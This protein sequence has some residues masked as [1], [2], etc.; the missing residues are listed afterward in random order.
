MQAY[1]PRSMEMDTIGL[2]PQDKPGLTLSEK[3]MRE[4]KKTEIEREEK[5]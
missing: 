3:Y 1:N 5:L 4:T 2:E